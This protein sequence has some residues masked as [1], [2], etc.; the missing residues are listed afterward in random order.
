MLCCV[1]YILRCF[2]TWIL[3]CFKFI[4]LWFCSISMCYPKH[5][6]T[7]NLKFCR[8]RSFLHSGPSQIHVLSWVA[9]LKLGRINGWALLADPPA[10]PDAKALRSAVC[11]TE[12]QQVFGLAILSFHTIV[13]MKS[14]AIDVAFSMEWWGSLMPSTSFFLKRSWLAF[15]HRFSVFC[16]FLW[17]SP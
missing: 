15:V 9:V 10:V 7:A 16:A 2:S 14:H 11:Q 12:T 8:I 1:F 4:L 13:A 17:L 3:N 5:S 6:N